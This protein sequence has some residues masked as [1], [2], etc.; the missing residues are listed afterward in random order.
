MASVVRRAS[1]ITFTVEGGS[2]SHSLNTLHL[3]NT[4]MAMPD[5]TYHITVTLL[6]G[7]YSPN[8][9]IIIIRYE[10]RNEL[11]WLVDF[12]LINHHNI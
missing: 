2:V 4:I 3:I 9:V 8:S 6:S 10:W 11:V 1:S 12:L 7:V 5:V